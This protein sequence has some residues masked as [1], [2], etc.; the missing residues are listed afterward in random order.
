MTQRSQPRWP[1][2][3][4]ALLFLAAA[5]QLLPCAAPAASDDLPITVAIDMV[6]RGQG[7]EALPALQRLALENNARAQYT[8]GTIYL[9][10]KWAPLDRAQGAA[11]L[12]IV[13]AGYPGIDQRE[14][15]LDQARDVLGKVSPGLTGPELIKA[16]RITADFIADWQQKWTHDYATAKAMV[17]QSASTA[18]SEAAVA[19]NGLP[20]APGCALDP[21]Q[22]GCW[23]PKGFNATEHCTG[24]IVLPDTAATADPDK[25]GKA[26]PTPLPYALMEGSVTTRVHVDRTGL[27]C[28]TTVV[29]SSGNAKLDR[30]VLDSINRWRFAPARQGT[31]DV[32]SL[33]LVKVTQNMR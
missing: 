24:A 19:S 14:L 17:A 3:H 16:D 7:T 26:R 5:V 1:R 6:A 28:F 31:T 30:A 20:L 4:R 11:W 15:V 27:V 22:R 33:R 32:E 2:R 25:G 29:R 12:Q 23:V 18:P 10:G 13:A 21:Q 9:E 8:L